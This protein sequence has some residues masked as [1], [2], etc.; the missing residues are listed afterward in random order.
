MKFREKKIINSDLKSHPSSGF[1]V[2]LND[3]FLFREREIIVLVLG[4]ENFNTFMTGDV[5]G[6]SSAGNICSYELYSGLSNTFN[7]VRKI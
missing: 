5:G 4:D 2:S 1:I 3:I 6:I 7:P